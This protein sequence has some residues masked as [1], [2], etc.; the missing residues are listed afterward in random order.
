MITSAYQI[1]KLGKKLELTS[2]IYVKCLPSQL[3]KKYKK[4]VSIG[5][6]FVIN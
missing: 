5:G 6:G 4:L 3:K 1:P 2:E